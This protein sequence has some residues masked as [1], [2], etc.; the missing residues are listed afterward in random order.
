MASVAERLVVDHDRDFDPVIQIVDVAAVGIDP[1]G[2]QQMQE[3]ECP[4]IV[5]FGVAFGAV[6]GGFVVEQPL[7]CEIEMADDL[8]RRFGVERSEQFQH[9][10]FPIQERA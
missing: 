3:R 4:Q 2:I 8:R 5:L 10:G 9:P 7:R 6:V 1:A